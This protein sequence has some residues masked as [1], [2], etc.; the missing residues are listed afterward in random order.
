MSDISKNLS[1]GVHRAV[2]A[3]E[4]FLLDFLFLHLTKISGWSSSDYQFSL[5]SIQSSLYIFRGQYWEPRH[6][7]V[8]E[9]P[10]QSA[11]WKPW[12]WYRERPFPAPAVTSDSNHG[13]TKLFSSCETPRVWLGGSSAQ[14][15]PVFPSPYS[16]TVLVAAVCQACGAVNSFRWCQSAQS[17]H[18]DATQISR[19]TADRTVTSWA[20]PLPQEQQRARIFRKHGLPPL[21]I[22]EFDPSVSRV[23]RVPLVH[24]ATPDTRPSQPVLATLPILHRHLPA[25]KFGCA[26]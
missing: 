13:V 10:S 18:E 15:R 1:G 17:T 12:H 8:L 23:P 20:P 9:E 3:S 25:Q 24:G 5:L 6:F 21:C 16:W 14:L 11:G 26:L 2:L 7:S 22:N 4:N 19:T